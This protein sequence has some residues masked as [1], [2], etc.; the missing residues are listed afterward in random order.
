MREGDKWQITLPY[1]IAYG[2]YGAGCVIPMYS[3]LNYDLELIKI[4]EDTVPASDEVF[5]KH[6]QKKYEDM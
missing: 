5:Q 6:F 3:A 1:E 4:H 2:Y